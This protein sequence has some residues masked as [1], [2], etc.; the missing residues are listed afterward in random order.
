[1]PDNV[2]DP[3]LIIFDSPAQP[4]PIRFEVAIANKPQI[5][6]V[7]EIYTQPI[8]FVDS[9]GYGSVGLVDGISC[10]SVPCT[11]LFDRFKIAPSPET[12]DIGHGYV[13][14]PSSPLPLSWNLPTCDLN[15]LVATIWQQNTTGQYLD[16]QSFSPGDLRAFYAA[17]NT[18][19]RLATVYR[20][21]D[22]ISSSYSC[23]FYLDPANLNV[24]QG[25][26]AIDVQANTSY[27]SCAKVAKFNFELKIVSGSDSIIAP[28]YGAKVD[29]NRLKL[30]TKSLASIDI[31]YNSLSWRSSHKITK[32]D[33]GGVIIG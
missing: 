11:L 30:D 9:L 15:Y 8:D 28:S 10:R 16:V 18:H 1:L 4:E 5:K 3:E 27:G 32:L 13:F 23:R 19:Y 14:S 29:F 12:S 17:A 31:Y 22:R 33:L 7:L 6:D 21:G 24:G 26:K 2:I 25:A 20:V